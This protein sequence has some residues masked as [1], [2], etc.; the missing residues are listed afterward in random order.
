MLYHNEEKNYYEELARRKLCHIWGFDLKNLQR[1]DKP[2]LQ[3][4][5]HSIGI[6]V[7]RATCELEEE[8]Y[9]K[10]KDI[11]DHEISTADR[12]KKIDKLKKMRVKVSANN[13]QIV[14]ISWSAGKPGLP[15]EVIERIK[16]KSKKE[17]TDYSTIGLFVFVETTAIDENHDSYVMEIM[18]QVAR[19]DNAFNVIF[20]D[21]GRTSCRCDMQ[22]ITF[23]RKT[24]TAEEKRKIEIE[25]KE[26]ITGNN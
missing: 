10:V 16:E 21:Q 12:I 8:T 15:E 20:L 14:S 11:L 1:K 24:I 23:E 2:D 25:A 9:K 13:D 4:P 22:N 26:T 18:Q 3:D 17:Y 5:K 19:Q 6:E 7:V